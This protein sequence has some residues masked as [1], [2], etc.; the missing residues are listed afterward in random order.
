MEEISEDLGVSSY[1]M[2]TSVRTKLRCLLN[3]E[4]TET[5]GTI[6][7]KALDN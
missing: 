1:K 2:R 4:E 3:E 5:H 7:E 6:Q